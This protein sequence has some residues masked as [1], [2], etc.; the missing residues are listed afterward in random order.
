MADSFA[1]ML[2]DLNEY[3][4]VGAKGGGATSDPVPRF[5]EKC[6][7]DIGALQAGDPHKGY[8]FL[9]RDPAKGEGHVVTFRTGTKMFRLRPGADF[10]V[11][12]SSETTIQLLTRAITLATEG[13]LDK[14]LN[15]QSIRYAKY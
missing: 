14:L 11:C 8:M 15:E 5:I 3:G 9:K 13:K 4:T 1:D 2:G 10:I 7:A 12:T 6:S